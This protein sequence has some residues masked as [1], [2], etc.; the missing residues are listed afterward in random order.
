MFVIVV[1]DVEQEKVA[2][3]I[4]QSVVIVT[5]MVAVHAPTTKHNMTTNLLLQL[6]L[7]ISYQ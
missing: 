7:Q 4:N 2:V 1:L 3:I 5:I 6:L